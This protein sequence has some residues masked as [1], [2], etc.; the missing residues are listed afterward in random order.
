MKSQPIKLPDGRWRIR[1]YPFPGS[2]SC[3]QKTAKTKKEC[4][5]WAN[6]EYAYL[7]GTKPEKDYRRLS[8]II[9][10]WYQIFGINLKSGYDR[11]NMML[12]FSRTIGN[13]KYQS[14]NSQHFLKW[15]SEAHMTANSKNHI[16][17]YLKTTFKKLSDHGH[18]AIKKNPLNGIEKLKFQETQMRY[19]EFFEIEMLLNNCEDKPLNLM[20]RIGLSTGFRWG[21]CK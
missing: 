13:P 20:I 7:H 21:A 1:I 8:D 5:E 12:S 3:R 17:T 10:L 19:L 9:D 15:R 18:I 16:H 2:K 14:F 6:R 11:K 4:L